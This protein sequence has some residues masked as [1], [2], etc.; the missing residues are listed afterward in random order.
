MTGQVNHLLNKAGYFLS[1]GAVVNQPI[2]IHLFGA[3]ANIRESLGMV[4]WKK[5]SLIQMYHIFPEKS[6]DFT[7]ES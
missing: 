6:V 5:L 1:G 7:R 4:F 2:F 3:Q